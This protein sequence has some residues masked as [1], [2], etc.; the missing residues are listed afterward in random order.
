MDRL[1]EA[2]KFTAF[3]SHL[4]EA[5]AAEVADIIT[6]PLPKQPY[7]SMLTGTWCTHETYGNEGAV[8]W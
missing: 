8:I 6:T 2:P 3:V 7:Q 1:S 4:S 5:Q